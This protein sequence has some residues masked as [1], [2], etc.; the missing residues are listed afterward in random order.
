MK[1][2]YGFYALPCALAVSQALASGIVQLDEV[3]VTGVRSN[4]PLV[5]ETDPRQPG[6]PVPA[7]DGAALLK[8][9]P[10]ISVTRKGGVSG[11]PLLRGLGGSRLAIMAD[12]DFLYGGCGGRMDP[13]TAYIY[14]DAYDKVEVIKG[15]QSVRFGTALISGAVNFS[16][17]TPRL[18][19][20]K[21]DGQLSLLTGSAGRLDGYAEATTGN[22]YAFVRVISSHNRGDDYRDGDGNKVHSAFER[23]S[24]TLM[25]GLTPGELTRL[26]LAADRSRGHA[27]YAD[28]MMDGSQFDRDAWSLKLAQQAITPWLDALRLQA[29]RSDVDHIMDNFSLRDG[30]SVAQRRLG[31]PDRQTDTASIE[32]DLALGALTLT[33]GGNWQRD[34]HRSR[35]GVDYAAKPWVTDQQFAGRGWFAE[36]R[37][38]LGQSGKLIAGWRQD[39]IKASYEQDAANSATREQ[40]YRTAS[41]FM[42]YEHQT[43]HWT[44]YFALGRAERTPDYWERNRSKTLKTERNLQLDIG[45][46][47]RT[48]TLQGNVS[49]FAGRIDD[50]IL[51]EQNGNTASARNIRAERAGLEADLSWRFA[52]Q[53]KTGATLAYTWARNHSDARP[54]AQTPPAEAGFSLGWDNGEYALGGQWRL[55][56]PQN[57]VAIGQGNIIGTDIGRNAGFGVLSLHGGWRASKSWRLSGGVD[58][59]LN[60]TYAEH[61]SKAGAMVTGYERS[62]R[63]NEAGRTFWLKL[64]GQWR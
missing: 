42:R 62:T 21:T 33:T 4:R 20:A 52:P 53:W 36:G 9:I 3:V 16:R 27:A 5:I 51:T 28:R 26:T 34:R 17:Q 18:S 23:R 44:P 59:V 7:A 54:L 6:Q 39:H 32:A 15:P 48:E 37:Q 35:G 25:L 10:G 19:E 1:R 57:R 38:P 24:E 49:L 60:K 41:G 11:D 56:A 64:Q 8:T 29:G 55:V 31:N 58:N 45:S 12:G 61:I 14:P 13:P 22:E 50:F 30:T 43:G 46:Q 2:G 63:V 47:Y 40:T